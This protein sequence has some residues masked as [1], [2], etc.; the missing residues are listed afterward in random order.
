MRPL[1]SSHCREDDLTAVEK[2]ATVA[3]CAA[4]KIQKRI[5]RGESAGLAHLR[6]GVRRE[7]LSTRNRFPR[8]SLSANPLRFPPPFW[9]YSSR[10]FGGDHARVAS[11]TEKRRKK[12]LKRN[13]PI[14]AGRHARYRTLREV[15]DKKKIIKC[16][17][18]VR[19][20]TCAAEKNRR[21]AEAL[22]RNPLIT[23]ERLARR[24]NARIQS[25]VFYFINV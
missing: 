22:S 9:S 16:L 1:R 5:S 15:N 7:Y 2:P 25:R 8:V 18:V 24:S 21:G 3:H 14:T 11:Q 17:G 23:T 12:A 13:S 6:A 19:W 20:P 4:G 10:W